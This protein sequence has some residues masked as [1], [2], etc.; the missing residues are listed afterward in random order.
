MLQTGTCASISW[1]QTPGGGHGKR[2]TLEVLALSPAQRQSE[3][4]KSD[5]SGVINIFLP[6]DAVQGP[7][8]IISFVD[9]DAQQG[10]ISAN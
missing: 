8:L 7:S 9:L 5:F 6:M 4:A 3:Q 10:R 2:A 1:L